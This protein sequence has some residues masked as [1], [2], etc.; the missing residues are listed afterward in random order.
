MAGPTVIYVVDDDASICKAIT[1]LLKS[2]G[3]SAQAF[4]SAEDFLRV[5]KVQSPDCLLLDIRMPEMNGLELQRQ[6][7]RS[8]IRIPVIFI[9][10]FD[11]DHTRQQ[12]REAGAAGYFCKPFDDEA[13]LD[14]IRFAVGK[15]GS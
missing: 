5:V 15:T 7:T 11:D 4:Q 2:A 14:A 12:A 10:A 8:G 3:L 13:L 6:L 9:T 1:R